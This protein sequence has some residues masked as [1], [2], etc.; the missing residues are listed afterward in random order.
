MVLTKDRSKSF[1]QFV[2]VL[3]GTAMDAYISTLP[4]NNSVRE[5][6]GQWRELQHT[7]RCTAHSFVM[8]IHGS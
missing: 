2:A 3:Q 5:V 1:Y 6:A 4:R 7:S 8:K